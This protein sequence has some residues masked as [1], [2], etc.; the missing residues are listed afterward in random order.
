M[1][2]EH[3]P[4]KAH[5]TPVGSQT[6]MSSSAH[7]APWGP[8]RFHCII[9]SSV[10]ASAAPMKLCLIGRIFSITTDASIYQYILRF[11]NSC[12][13]AINGLPYFVVCS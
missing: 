4:K 5:K 6:F 3:R 13:K 7:V 9:L 8:V 1:R 11:D 12:K 10:L 2:R